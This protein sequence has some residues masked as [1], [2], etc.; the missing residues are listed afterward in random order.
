MDLYFDHAATTPL[1]PR[2][3]SAMAEAERDAWGNAAS[4]HESGVRAA[5]VVARARA[6][7]GEA[8]GGSPAGV[9]FTSGGTEANNLA[10]KGTLLLHATGH[11]VTTAVEHPSVLEPAR[12]LAARGYELTI[13]PVDV[14]GFVDPAA[15]EAAIRPETALVSVQAANNEIGT[16]Q[17]LC[18][19]G[20]IC[21][22]HGVRFHTDACQSFGR[23]ALRV[24]EAGLDLVTVNGHKMHGPKGVGA[25]W[26]RPGTP[27][28]PL[29]HGGGQEGGARG[30]TTNTPAIAGF[31]AAVE[32]VTPDDT[33][34]MA[35]LRDRILDVVLAWPGV[36]LNG[37]RDRRLPHH[38]SVVIPGILASDLVL[39]LSAEGVAVSAGSACHGAGSPP[40][41][42]LTAIGRT[43][44]EAASSIRITLAR[45]TRP[46]EVEA[47]LGILE[48]CLR[49]LRGGRPPPS[50]G[51]T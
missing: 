6:V 16:L 33:P 44:E 13:L 51:G 17:D 32:A 46:E 37:P 4:L 35:S 25:L 31:A 22:A 8:L 24:E 29:L 39:A 3:A 34:S 38:V 36:R 20:R 26:V 47:M 1:D 48:A 23:V 40:S 14:H 10:L 11:L 18:A 7:L 27:L 19:V 42:I 28:V 15:V 12:W 41:A 50:G 30:G 21:R 43:H 45:T 5:R 2:A 9:V 49:R